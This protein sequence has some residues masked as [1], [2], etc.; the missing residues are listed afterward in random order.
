MQY[1]RTELPAHFLPPLS[2]APVAE[3]L[4]RR[5]RLVL[6]APELAEIAEEPRFFRGLLLGAVL[7]LVLIAGIAAAASWLV[8]S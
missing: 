4:P 8:A 1:A 6:D 7:N 5:L 2:Q 3:P